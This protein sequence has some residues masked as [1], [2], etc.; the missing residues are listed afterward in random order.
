MIKFHKW[1]FGLQSR[2]SSASSRLVVLDVSRLIWRVWTGRIPT[3]ID[4]VCLAYLTHFG[5]DSL[6][7]VQRGAFRMVFDAQSSDRLFALLAA[8][9]TRFRQSLMRW[10]ARALLRHYRGQLCGKIYLNAGHTG[11]DARGLVTW[12]QK[13][14]MRPVFLI[15]DL[16]PISHPQFCRSGEGQRHSRRIKHALECAAGIIAN[17]QDTLDA[18]VAF[19]AV[20]GHRLDTIKTTVAW[21]GSYEPAKPGVETRASEQPFFLVVGTIEARKNHIVL[22]RVWHRLFERLRQNVP[23]LIVVGQRGWEASDAF[24]LL[25]EA[26]ARS[27]GV[28]ELDQCS[29]AELAV[30]LRQARALLMPS[31]AEG[32]GLPVV[33]ALQSGLPVIASD[34]SVFRELFGSIP[35]YLDPSDELAWEA[36]IMDFAAVS[37]ERERQLQ[38]IKAFQVPSWEQHFAKVEA[39]LEQVA[40]RADQ[41]ISA[42]LKF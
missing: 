30:L 10:F 17:S 19:A 29:N 20:G 8:G 39:L 15:H 11:L 34:L 36:A 7:M 41:A 3:G 18:L 16:I 42:E 5:P 4:K 32:F 21:L 1:S 2:K 6:A 37:D 31:F 23:R 33:E 27:V 13:S 9:G 28:Q 14:G 12:L 40:D 25:D 24:A 38:A 22:L 26:R 35:L